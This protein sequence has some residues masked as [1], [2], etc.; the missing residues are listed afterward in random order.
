MY[1]M[2]SFVYNLLQKGCIVIYLQLYI[3]FHHLYIT[4][5]K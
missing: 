4:T 3:I 2:L 5:N 1:D